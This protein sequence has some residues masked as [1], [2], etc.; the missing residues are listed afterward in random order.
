MEEYSIANPGYLSEPFMK[1]AIITGVT[2]Q[3]GAYL[4]QW[5]LG[6]GYKVIGLVRSKNSCDLRGLRYLGIDKEVSIEECNLLDISNILSLLQKYQVDELYNL[7]AQSSVGTSFVQP[8]GTIEF[9]VISVLNLLESIKRCNCNIRFYQAST[10][11]MFGSIDTLPVTEKT[12]VH[13]LSPYAI[14]KA[15]AHWI[16]V[17]YRESYHLFASSGILFN[18][19]SYLRKENYFIKKLIQEAL[20]I[21]SGRRDCLRVGNIDVRRDFGYA[22]EYVK[23]MW[24]MLQSEKPDDFIICSGKSILL[25]DAIDH[26]FNRLNI[27]QQ[28]LVIDRQ[29]YRPNDITDIYGDS[30]K[31][32]NKLKWYY[33][34]DFFDVLDM[35]IEEELKASGR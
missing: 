1:T 35:L 8:L 19:E 10:S 13:P 25:R 28:R 4:S 2:G 27:S 24:L 11:E 18:H 17:Q 5:L 33:E 20:E 26:V 7:A 22:P 12:V 16:T 29:L 23:A 6:K 34:L 21:R 9:N 30:S 31:A 32:K 14:S 3:D 15:S